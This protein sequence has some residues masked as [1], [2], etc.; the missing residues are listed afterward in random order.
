M[1]RV[2]LYESNEERERYDNRADLFSIIVAL[3]RVDT[4]YIR[5][6]MAADEYTTLCQSLLCK[7]KA[8]Y[9][10]LG[11]G[12]EGLDAFMA[13]YQLSQGAKSAVLGRIK[14]GV[15]MTKEHGTGGTSSE[16]GR[17]ILE[18]GQHMIACT[19]ALKMGH[20]SADV[21]HPI[22]SDIVATVVKLFPNLPELESLRT[23]L[24]DINRLKAA[25][26][27]DTNQTRQLQ[28]DIECAYGALHKK[29]SD[30]T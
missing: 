1:E 9:T 6:H 13:E 18:A 15:P 14:S 19:D 21:L 28:Y 20:S 5:D 10:N 23:W 17:L 2:K 12:I 26:E 4:A 16:N 7:C 30:P 29:L 11:I 8:S 27:L 22:I 25:E 24:R 3:E